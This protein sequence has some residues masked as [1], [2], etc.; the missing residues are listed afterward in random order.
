MDPS[1]QLKATPSLPITLALLFV[2]F[3]VLP[4]VQAVVPPPDGG[5]PNF[6]T[7]EGT[8]ALFSLT[9][10]SA[11]TA[12]GWFSVFSD[13]TGTFNTAVGATALLHNTIAE[14]NTATG[15]FALSSNTEGDFNTATGAFALAG[16]T[17]G[18]RNTPKSLFKRGDSGAQSIGESRRRCLSEDP[19]P[20]AFPPAEDKLKRRI[21]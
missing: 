13:T 7:A 15:A 10:G 14:E 4:N 18:V 9:T 20:A 17:T 12:V 19:A 3:G 16:N 2:C 11:N 5:Y 1:I 8:K 21:T 6:T